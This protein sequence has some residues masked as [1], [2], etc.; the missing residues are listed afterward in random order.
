MAMSLSFAV[1]KGSGSNRAWRDPLEAEV[2]NEG[3]NYFP[4]ELRTGTLEP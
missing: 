1:K 2:D 3:F 4:L